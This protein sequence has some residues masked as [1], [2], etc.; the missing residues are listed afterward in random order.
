MARIQPE[1]LQAIMNIRNMLIEDHERILDGGYN[2]PAAL[3]K[4][5]DVAVA[6]SRAIRALEEV[7]ATGGEIKFEKA[8]E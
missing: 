1:D 4:Q 5:S 2:A 7:M 8:T 3:C 6:F